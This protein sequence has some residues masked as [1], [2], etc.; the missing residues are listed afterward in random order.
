MM[1]PRPITQACSGLLLAVACAAPASPTVI[2]ARP[3]RLAHPSPQGHSHVIVE[4]ETVSVDPSLGEVF[5]PPHARVAAKAALLSAARAWKR[6]SVQAGVHRPHPV[7]SADRVY[8]GTLGLPHAGSNTLV[9][10]YASP[11]GGCWTD[12]VAPTNPPPNMPTRCRQWTFIDAQTGR[13][14]DSTLASVA[15]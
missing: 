14:V 2:S 3:R 1:N 6:M 15:T 5:G 4:A 7:Q 11:I 12:P 13:L 9:Y 8:L 10:G